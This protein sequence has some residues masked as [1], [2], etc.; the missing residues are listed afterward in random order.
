MGRK[1]MSTPKPSAI[2]FHTGHNE[3]LAL[4]EPELTH[5]V[6]LLEANGM[7]PHSSNI[8]ISGEELSKFRVVV[9]GNPL[10]MKFD[11]HEITSLVSFVEA[12]GGLLLLSGATIFGKGGDAARKTNLNEI[13]KHFQFKFS[14]KAIERPKDSPDEM[15]TAVPAKDHPSNEGIH[16]LQFTSGVSLL[17]EDAGIHLFRVSNIA[18][19][20]TIAIATDVKKGRVIAFGGGTFFFNDY[21]GIGDHEQ[22]IVQL[23][24]WLSDE[25]L[26]LPFTKISIPPLIHDEASA[27]EAI[28]ELRQQLDRIEE[29]LASLKEIISSSVKE[30]EKLMRKIQNDAKE[31]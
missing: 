6:K 31:T 29:E 18:G 13:A 2:L 10:D 30:M 7:A 26:N 9:L 27:N 5:L 20:P 11:S 23:F 19:N 22:L 17:A 24:R 16:N 1:I 15:I 3:E 8:P 14:T 12:G 21:I 28:V 4:D 25:P